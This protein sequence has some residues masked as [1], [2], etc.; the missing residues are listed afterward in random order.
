MD[1]KLVEGNI[2]IDQDFVC[3]VA[4]WPHDDLVSLC[5]RR[6]LALPTCW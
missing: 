6:P 2:C 1:M 3:I 5:C 4:G